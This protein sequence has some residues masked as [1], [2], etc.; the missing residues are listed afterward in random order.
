[1]SQTTMIEMP[2][3]QRQDNVTNW[4]AEQFR[5][6]YQDSSISK[7]DIWFYI[8][9]VMHA[10]DWR[11]TYAKDLRESLPRVPL[12][13][14]FAAFRDAGRELMDLHTGYESCPE[15]ENVVCQVDGTPS[16]DDAADPEVYR[17][18]DRMRWSKFNLPGI[19]DLSESESQNQDDSRSSEVAPKFDKTRLVIN[20]RCELV[21][22]P[23]Q[24]HNYTVS[25]RSPLEWEVDSLR[26]KEDKRSGIT[27]DPNTC[28]EWADNPF[29]LI[30]HLR[31]L[32]YVSVKSAEIIA[33]LPASINLDA[34]VDPKP[35]TE[36]RK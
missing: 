26:H 33:S 34:A 8:Y 1:L 27:D 7:D 3:A 20:P 31:R 22:I 15:Y 25:G 11:K 10:P 16:E 32:V 5:G 6:H 14:D 28:E 19:A 35:S 17:I 13:P 23:L 30:R 2:E 9:G 21:N 29:E 4:A 12:A 24:A 36:R 18:A